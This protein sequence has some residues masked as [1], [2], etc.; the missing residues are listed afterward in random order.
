MDAVI[1]SIGTEL[2]TGRQVDTNSAWLSDELTRR[3]VGVA[4]HVTVGDDLDHIT[5]AITEA[6]RGADL[7]VITG[8]LGPTPDDLTRTALAAAIDRPL[9]ENSEAM[10]QLQAMFD[11]WQRP[12]T[13]PNKVQ[14]QI[15]EGCEVVRN[16][17]GT[18]PGIRFRG[19]R[20]EL[21]A[22]PGVPAEMRDMFHHAIA[23]VVADLAG[24]AAALEATLLCY[25]ISEAKVGEL[26]SDLMVRDRNPLVGTAAARGVIGVRIL[27]RGGDRTTAESLLARDMREIR[28]RLGR[29]VF[30][31][32]DDTLERCVGRL[33]SESRMSIATA[34]SCT[35]GLLAKRLTDIPG[36]SSYFVRGYITYSNQAKVDLLSVAVE[37]IAAHGAV[38]EPV[39]RAMASGCRTGAGSDLALSITGIAGPG[40]GAPPDK[41]VGL[42]YIGLATREEI[43]AKRLLVGEHL[44]RE[45]IRDR[46][47]SAALNLLRR[48]LTRSQDQPG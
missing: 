13:E 23:P 32:G 17:S 1:I 27:A 9:E 31:E 5:G 47:S 2:T 10:G 46:A 30:G 40:G 36:S 35:G 43:V 11:R 18:A 14:A 22:L 34:E 41:P 20:C 12:L 42:V 28:R 38:S 24:G 48:R 8:G 7:V 33:L 16:D 39:A 44:S 4:R 25:G 26:L 45:E 29:A 37:L 19:E 6:I 21:F 15:P 3:G